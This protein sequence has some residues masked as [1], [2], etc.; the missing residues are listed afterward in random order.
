[1]PIRQELRGRRNTCV[2]DLK[3]KNDRD[4]E[5]MKM[6]RRTGAMGVDVLNTESQDERQIL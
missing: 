1:M 3:R 6:E 4:S 2:P 5:E